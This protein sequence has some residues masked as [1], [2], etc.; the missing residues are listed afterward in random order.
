MREPSL[1]SGLCRSTPSGAGLTLLTD[2]ASASTAGHGQAHLITPS[3]DA[4][5]MLGEC[6]RSSRHH[7]DGLAR[8]IVRAL[9]VSLIAARR[10]HE[11]DR[12]EGAERRHYGQC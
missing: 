2:S 6:L 3:Q 10:H 1:K 11:G 4:A 9:F 12:R 7:R 5:G 8:G